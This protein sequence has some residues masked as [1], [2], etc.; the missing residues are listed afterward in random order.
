MSGDD[1]SAPRDPVGPVLVTG[2][3][4]FLGSHLLRELSRQSDGAGRV[5]VLAR[6]PS[7]EL[8]ARGVEVV[9]GDLL[10]GSA[11]DA[12]L[13]GVRR[14]F[15]LA[16]MVSRDPDAAGRLQQVHVEGTRRL[17]EAAERAGIE[18]VV[19]VSTSGT[20]AVS[21][22]PEPEL[23]ET[24]PPPIDLIG[25]WPYYRSKW[26]Q[27]RVLESR[28]QAFD[29]VIVNPSLLLGPGDERLSST[30]DVLRFLAGDVLVIPPGGLNFV[31][32]RDAA[33][34]VAAA[35]IRGR[36][37]RRYLLGGHNWSFADF[38]ERLS[39]V[40]GV[41]PPRVRLPRRL[42]TAAALATEEAARQLGRAPATDRISRE[43]AARYWYFSSARAEAELGHAV[44][45][46]RLTLLET[47]RWLEGRGLA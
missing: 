37:G 31:D 9:E 6:R 26:L 17:A 23:D 44:R 13:A 10:D 1:P 2:A 45:D 33:R 7:P 3:T 38:F 28:R 16:G 14:V 18:R 4:G 43:M 30:G 40:S 8:T 34:S 46:G 24:S 22:E 42:Y 32:V 19:L 47:V 15:H 25:G 12:A 27:E 29:V 21:V 20:I 41:P 39:E 35:M 11:L 36:P 5:R